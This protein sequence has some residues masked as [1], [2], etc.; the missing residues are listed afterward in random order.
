M[1]KGIDCEET[2]YAYY[3]YYIFK[4]KLDVVYSGSEMSAKMHCKLLAKVNTSSP[5]LLIPIYF[6]SKLSI[7]LIVL[8]S[9]LLQLTLAH[10]SCPTVHAGYTRV[11]IQAFDSAVSFADVSER[12]RKR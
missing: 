12:M 1:Q 2:L 11:T 7:Y 9:S 10:N 3:A 4:K 6:K 5:R 8:D